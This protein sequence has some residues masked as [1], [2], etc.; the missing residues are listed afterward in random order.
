MK[1]VVLLTGSPGRLGSAFCE[2]YYDNYTIVGVARNK[3]ANFAHH[4][5]EAD[6]NV[7]HKRVVDETLEKF[8][9]IDVL[10]NNAAT[11]AIKPVSQLHVSEMMELYQTNLF[12]PYR[13]TMCV[14]HKFWKN[15][16]AKNEKLKRNVINVSSISSRQV[17]PNQAAY[18]SSKAALNMLSL[19]LA[20]ELEPFGLRVNV[21]SPTA[22]PAK[23]SCEEVADALVDLERSEKNGEI[24][25]IE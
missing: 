7:D 13:L 23:V 9:R 3:L 25:E 24:V 21:L 2:K 19:H 20:R 1:K 16:A 18:A 6:I 12:S 4:F 14:F 17:W 15:K 5:I 8:G 10:I 22:F 11:Y